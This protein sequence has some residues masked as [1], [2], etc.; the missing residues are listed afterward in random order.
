MSKAMKKILITGDVCID[1]NIATNRSTDL[2][3]LWKSKGEWA[4][5]F[6]ED[7]GAWLIGRIIKK[8]C[9]DTAT[10]DVRACGADEL[11]TIINST[12]IDHLYNMWSMFPTKKSDENVWRVEKYIGLRSRLKIEPFPNE[13]TP[14]SNVDLLIIDDKRFGFRGKEKTEALETNSKN[15][16]PDFDNANLIMLRMARD[17]CVGELWSE[18]IEKHANKLIVVFTA[19]D[20]RHSD[21]RVSRELSWEQTIGDVRKALNSD[22]YLKRLSE[23]KYV[24]VSF[25][26]AGVLIYAP[27]NDD[28]TKWTIVYDAASM[29]GQAQPYGNGRMNGYTYC[30]IGA[31]AHCFAKVDVDLKNA[32]DQF[33]QLKVA[34]RLGI[35]AMKNLY[36]KGY[37]AVPQYEKRCEAALNLNTDEDAKYIELRF[38]VDRISGEIQKMA[39]E[40]SK[41]RLNSEFAVHH[42]PEDTSTKWSLMEIVE[43][44]MGQTNLCENIIRNGPKHTLKGV[45]MCKFNKLLIVDRDEIESLH[46]IRNTILEFEKKRRGSGTNHARPLSIAVFGEPGSGKSFA[47]KQLTESLGLFPKPEMLEFNLSQFSDPK[48][49]VGAFHQVRDAVLKG[50]LPFVFWDEFDSALGG[51]ELGWLKYFLAPM[52]DGTFQD[53]QIT[54]AVGSCVFIFAGGTYSSFEKFVDSISQQQEKG[55]AGSLEGS[56]KIDFT[57][58]TDFTSRLMGHLTI[59]GINYSTD[60]GTLHEKV[61]RAILLRAFLENH[62]QSIWSNTRNKSESGLSIPNIHDNVLKAFMDIHRYKSGARS[63]EAII[64]MSRLAGEIEFTP[65]ALPS[66]SQLEIFVAGEEFIKLASGAV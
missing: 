32:S 13:S 23:C 47:V 12:D 11:K 4:S 63:M 43:T 26:A 50:S 48:E 39:A 57:K 45:P 38:P 14:S 3:N 20:L 35:Y 46:S 61:R 22:N 1:W 25:D 30:L 29:E 28:E 18:L 66:I 64:M 37:E 65:S 55:T 15:L 36:E 42:L 7:G 62:A 58:K 24:L 10:V 52:Q 9:A 6:P 33:E 5:A 44:A 34:A 41:D 17:L 27:N 51:H 54:H 8:V 49:I 40:N 31:L 56:K 53:G 19:N 2:H 60:S 16:W 59:K 21:V